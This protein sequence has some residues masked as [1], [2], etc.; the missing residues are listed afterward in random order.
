[1]QWKHVASWQWLFIGKTGRFTHNDQQSLL[2]LQYSGLCTQI[3]SEIIWD[4]AA[5]IAEA[6]T[7]SSMSTPSMGILVGWGEGWL[8][9]HSLVLATLISSPT[10]M[11]LITIV[12]CRSQNRGHHDD[13]CSNFPTQVYPVPRLLYAKPN[14]EPGTGEEMMIF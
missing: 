8:S 6:A 13:T 9:S 4:V 2:H 5:E 12:I 3:L 7:T 14:R 11:P 10:C 1:M